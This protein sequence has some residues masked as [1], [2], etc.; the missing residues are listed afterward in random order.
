MLSRYPNRE[1][2]F[3]APSIFEEA[4]DDKSHF[5]TEWPESPRFE[6]DEPVA[7]PPAQAEPQRAISSGYRA[8][9]REPQPEWHKS[10]PPYNAGHEK[11]EHR[12]AEDEGRDEHLAPH[13]E[14]QAPG[15][16][17]KPSGLASLLSG[18]FNGRHRI[19]DLLKRFNIHLEFDDILLILIML[20][21]YLESDDEEI[22]ILLALSL[23]MGD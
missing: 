22:L 17:H 1:N 13:R 18:Q 7:P 11:P 10:R 9:D 8:R 5:S 23:F 19:T 21:L 14:S 15:R 16:L 2:I 3:G 4:A 12:H 6:R 20:F